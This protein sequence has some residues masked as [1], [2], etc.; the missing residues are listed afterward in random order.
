MCGLWVSPL[1][2]SYPPRFACCVPVV[3]RPPAGLRL[4]LC[5][6]ASLS[7]LLESV[8]FFAVLYLLLAFLSLSSAVFFGL[9]PLYGLSVLCMFVSVWIAFVDC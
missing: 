3:A 7:A 1:L 2:L 9:W 6:S 8:M 4:A 5:L